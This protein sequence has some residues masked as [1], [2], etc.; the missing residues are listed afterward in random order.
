MQQKHHYQG[1]TPAEVEASRRQYGVN[2]LTPPAKDPLWVVFLKKFY[3]PLIIILLI[4]GVL[5]IGI[6]VYEYLALGKGAD[7]FLNRWAS[8]W[9][10]FWPRASLFTLR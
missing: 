2:V 1:L 9:L 4:A 5:S 7:V 3:D 8:L 6:A 10:S